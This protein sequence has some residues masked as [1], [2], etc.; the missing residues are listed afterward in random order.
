MFRK[1]NKTK[2]AE[3]FPKTLAEFGYYI[4]PDGSIRSL[5]SGTAPHSLAR[6]LSHDRITFPNES[7]L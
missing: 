2:Q 4:K 1:K 5:Q 3:V 7:Y 6:Q